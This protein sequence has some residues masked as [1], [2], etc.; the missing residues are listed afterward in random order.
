MLRYIMRELSPRE[1]RL[2]A[3]LVVVAFWSAISKQ[4]L[5]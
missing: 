1:G 2:L 5:L 4:V 3:L